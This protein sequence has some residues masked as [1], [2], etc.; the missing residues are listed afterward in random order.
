MKK[1]YFYSLGFITLAIVVFFIIP[2][3]LP[4]NNIVFWVTTILVILLL[5]GIIYDFS[6]AKRGEK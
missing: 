6:T 2:K 1:N 5:F 4:G 3:L